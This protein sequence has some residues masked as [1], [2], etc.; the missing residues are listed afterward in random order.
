MKVALAFL[1][2]PML[3]AE[4]G[5]VAGPILGL[6]PSSGGLRLVLG[7]P[8]AAMAGDALALEFGVSQAAASGGLAMAVTQP[9]GRVVAIGR[10]AQ[11]RAVEGASA[12]PAQLLLSPEARAAALYFPD[13]SVLEIVS[14]L[15]GAPAVT[16][17]IDLSGL[18]A[19]PGAMAVADDGAAVAF[20]AGSLYLLGPDLP[21]PVAAI[22]EAAALAF[23]GKDV[24]AA[25]GDWALLVQ[26]V[27]GAAAVRVLTAEAL[28]VRWRW[29][30]P[31]G[32]S[33]W[34]TPKTP[35]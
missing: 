13:A 27:A 12:G 26:D 11:W 23:S 2:V 22:G 3:F 19:P 28:R 31:A 10:D 33:W 18:P 9:D 20:A 24:V 16:R 15:P 32:A 5:D 35:P 4:N 6:L 1:L 8:G 7:I 30:P 34:P 17:R 21:R 25:G 14:G 29:L